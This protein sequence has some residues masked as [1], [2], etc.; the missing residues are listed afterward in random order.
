MSRGGLIKMISATNRF[1]GPV[2]RRMVAIA[3][4]AFCLLAEG[5]PGLVKAQP[6]EPWTTPSQLSSGLLD[7]TGQPM[8]H[9]FPALVADPWGNAHAFWTRLRRE[10]EAS[11]D[12][13]IFYSQWTAGAWSLPTDVV[14]VPKT[15]IWRPQAA[16][17]RVGRINL[18]WTAG[19]GGA[20]WYS[21]APAAEAGSARAWSEPLQ[22]SELGAV[23]VGLAVD[24][25]GRRHVVYCSGDE[26]DRC[27][28]TASEDSSAWNSPSLIHAGCPD[29]DARVAVDA[30]GRIHAVVGSQAT[31][32]TVMYYSRSEDGGLTW[33]DAIV[34]DKSSDRFSVDYGPAWGTVVTQGKDQVHVIWFGA[35]SGHRWHRWSS[36]GGVTWS[37]A[38]QISADQRGLTLPVATAFDSA[39]VL[40]VISMG[41]READGLVSGAF[42]LTWQDGRWS[43]PKLI[44][45]RSDWDA[46]YAA[47]TVA[48]GNRLVAAWTDKKG[49]KETYQIWATTLTVDAPAVEPAAPLSVTPASPEPLLQPEGAR[50]TGATVIGDAGQ[51]DTSPQGIAVSAPEPG[52][53]QREW[54]TYLLGVLPPMALLALVLFVRAARQRQGRG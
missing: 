12:G 35:P 48:A 1:V 17:D 42:H 34:L 47:V 43:E 9:C 3:L 10:D 33:A 4:L 2:L 53:G 44:G 28:H 14:L 22:I 51:P 23:G 31:K 46:E 11:F 24:Q 13:L 8:S 40:H 50:P 36:D 25:A 32:G 19:Y 5:G 54:L 38:E 27:Y 18:V 6:P 49:P 7:E 26:D 52:S 15:V 16:I 20:V 29:C 39:G 41:W 21:S 30:R 37:Q 45:P